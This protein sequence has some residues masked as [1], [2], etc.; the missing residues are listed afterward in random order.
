MLQVDFTLTKKIKN[1]WKS[2][3]NHTLSRESITNKRT[4]K[5]YKVLSNTPLCTLVNLLV[6][7]ATDFL[8]LIPIGRHIEV[9]MNVMGKYIIIDI[10]FRYFLFIYS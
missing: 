4:Y 6:L 9:K 10:C 2:Q 8:E 3:G 7:R 5:E 1:I